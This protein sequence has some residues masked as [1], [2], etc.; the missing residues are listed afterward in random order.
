AGGDDH[1]VVERTAEHLDPFEID[2]LE[3]HPGF[4][5]GGVARLRGQRVSQRRDGLPDL[6]EGSL[7][8]RR[9]EQQGELWKRRAWANVE[10]DLVLEE[11][12]EAFETQ[13]EHAFE[14]ADAHA[15]R[16]VLLELLELR[17]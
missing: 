11:R 7:L 9:F 17:F 16:V 3:L 1:L 13:P 8:V 10:S 14:L 6:V 4:D 15:I 12:E 5:R 2:A